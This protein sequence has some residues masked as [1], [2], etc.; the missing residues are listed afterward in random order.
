MGRRRADRG[1]SEERDFLGLRNDRGGSA[2][3]YR[4]HAHL[5]PGPR[6]EMPGSAFQETVTSLSNIL[7]VHDEVF[8]VFS[9]SPAQPAAPPHHCS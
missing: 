9:S 6:G 3:A 1:G 4:Q 7:D 5:P 2:R 8:H